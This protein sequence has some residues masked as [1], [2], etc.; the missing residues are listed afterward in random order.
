MRTLEELKFLR[1]AFSNVKFFEKIEQQLGE[2]Q[3]L[4]L[5]SKLNVKHCKA[6]EKLFEAGDTSKP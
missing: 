1:E 6:G 2:E 3:S 4:R 5:F